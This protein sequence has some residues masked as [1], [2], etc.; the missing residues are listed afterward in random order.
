MECVHDDWR[1]V[2]ADHAVGF[3]APEWPNRSRFQ[4]RFLVLRDQG[5]GHVGN[6]FW[7]SDR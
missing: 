4:S 3:V 2:V 1:G 6:P 5:L 7:L